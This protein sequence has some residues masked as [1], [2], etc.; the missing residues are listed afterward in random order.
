MNLLLKISIVLLV[1]VIGGRVAKIFKL[2][3]VSGYLVAGLL[4][5][6]SFL[7]LVSGQDIESFSVISELALAIIAFSISPSKVNAPALG[8]NVLKAFVVPELLLPYCLIS[9][10]LSFPIKKPVEKQPNK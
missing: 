9:T 1:G 5:G 4:L 3:N 10:L 2:P 8:P 6:P 7:K